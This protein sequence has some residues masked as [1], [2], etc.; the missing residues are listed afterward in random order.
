MPLKSNSIN[1]FLFKKIKLIVFDFDGV[2]TDNRVMVDG[3][4]REAVFCHRADGLGINA[5]QKEKMSVIVISTEKNLVVAARCK[6]LRLRCYQGVANKK[7]L[8]K[9]YLLDNK[10]SAENVAYVGND[11][12]DLECF[13]FVGLAVAVADSYP[14]IIANADY[15]LKTK[16]GYG[17]VR[18]FCDLIIKNN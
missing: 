17:A 12:N 8:L 7:E 6:K 5:L 11:I 9:K 1:K 4:G 3:K 14:E 18:E 10:I 16:G 15:V 2:M 13:K